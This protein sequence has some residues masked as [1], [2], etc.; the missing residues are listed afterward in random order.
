MRPKVNTVN[1]CASLF[2][3]LSF[4]FKSDVLIAL[5]I[6]VALFVIFNVSLCSP[7]LQLIV[8]QFLLAHCFSIILKI[9]LFN[10]L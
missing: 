6:Y 7:I 3:F 5:L 10:G 2:T 9:Y 4:S 1:G 8:M